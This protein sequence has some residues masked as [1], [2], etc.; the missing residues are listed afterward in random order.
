MGK[1]KG[2][3]NDPLNHKNLHTFKAPTRLPP[4][5]EPAFRFDRCLTAHTRCGDRLPIHMVDAITGSIKA[6]ELG[7]YLIA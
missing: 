6:L 7:L 2:Q 3:F 4:L 1:R 5:S